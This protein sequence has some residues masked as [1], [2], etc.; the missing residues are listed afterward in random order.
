MALDR[1]DRRI[2][3]QPDQRIPELRCALTNAIQGRR[4]RLETLDRQSVAAGQRVDLRPLLAQLVRWRVSFR[5]YALALLGPVAIIGGAVLGTVALGGRV[6][7]TVVLPG[8]QVLPLR[9]DTEG[10]KVL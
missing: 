4:R 1:F 10:A 2:G 5:W 9:V 7:A 6:D 8:W 3:R